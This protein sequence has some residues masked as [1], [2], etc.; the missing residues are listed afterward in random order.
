MTGF[1]NLGENPLSR[2]TAGSL[3]DLGYKTSMVGEKYDL[4]RNTEGVDPEEFEPENMVDGI[5]IGE[6]EV[7]LEPV[8]YVNLD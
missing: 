3:R 6:M 2:I 8:G 5:N 7:I 4:P 1:I